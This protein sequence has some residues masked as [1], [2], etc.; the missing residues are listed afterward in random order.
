M[1]SRTTENFRIA[2]GQKERTILNTNE[3]IW[4]GVVPAPVIFNV[5]SFD[6][7]DTDNCLL[8]VTLSDK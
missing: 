4:V 7:T 1:E 5:S 3:G 2:P 8:T 6:K